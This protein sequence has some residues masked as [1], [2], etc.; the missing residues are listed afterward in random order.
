MKCIVIKE[1]LCQGTKECA[2][3]AAEA[4][5]FTDDGVAHATGAVLADEIADRIEAVCPSMAITT[6]EVQTGQAQ[7]H[8]QRSE[9]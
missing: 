9:S 4:V 3:V 2:A 7:Q 5:E 1:E 8:F 6:T